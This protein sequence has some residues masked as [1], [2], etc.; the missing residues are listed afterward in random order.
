MVVIT[1]QRNC[2]HFL[3][4][5]TLHKRLKYILHNLF[6]SY[7]YGNC[8]CILVC[9]SPCMCLVPKEGLSDPL[10]FKFQ[11]TMNCHVG[12]EDEIKDLIESSQS[13]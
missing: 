4:L 13:Y 9:R 3:Y 7:M 8:A 2:Q 5:G 11:I 6:P 10:E 1:E 12:S